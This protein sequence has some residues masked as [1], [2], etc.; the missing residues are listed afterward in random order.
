[1]YYEALPGMRAEWAGPLIA[2][3]FEQLK[4]EPVFNQLFI[5]K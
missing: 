5:E 3:F 1:M 4:Q 2:N